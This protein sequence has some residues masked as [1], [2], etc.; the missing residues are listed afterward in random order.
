MADFSSI[1]DPY[2][3]L[4]ELIRRDF[5]AFLRKAYPWISGGE[6]MLWN[7]HLDA[8]ACQL[9]RVA[10]GD[11]RRLLVTL[12]PRHGKSKTIT[13]AWVAWCLGQD[14]SANFVCVSY[15]NELSGKLARDCLAIMQSAWYREA[16]PRT[17][18][19]AK[20]SAVADF[21]TT[22]G[23]GRLATSVTGTLTGRGGDI[24]ILDDVIKP[25]EA[26]SEVARNFVNNWYQST[27]ASRLNDKA[28]GAI[29][30]VMQRLHQ[31]DLAGMLIESGEWDEL[32]LPAIASEDQEIRLTRNRL[33][34]R[35]AGDILHPARESCEELMRIQRTIGSVIFAA[36]YQQQ[37]VPAEGNMIR[38]E[39]LKSYKVAPDLALVGGQIVQSWDTASKDGVLN[40]WSVCITAWICRQQIFIVDVWRQ[41]VAFPDLKK[42]TIQ[43]ARHYRA[44]VLL[45]EDQASG[46]QLLQTLRNENPVGVPAP[47]ARKPEADKRTRLAG[48]SA[49]IEAGQLLLPDDAPWLGPFKH[50]LLAFPSSR[51][52]DQVDALSQLLTW[53]GRQMRMDIPTIG[54]PIYFID[55]Q[56]WT[57]ETLSSYGSGH[58][59]GFLFRDLFGGAEHPSLVRPFR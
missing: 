8:I 49:M 34:R 44:Q 10:R 38:T 21:E 40:D 18:I 5:G 17:I 53:A 31:Y 47:I 14:P 7:W 6:L 9:E 51:H 16:F 26:Q 4:L 19:S 48:V 42:A 43:N 57:P 2:A 32:S 58:S 15:S 52:D 36:Q 55:G 33:H 20:R 11:C 13:V 25:E 37:P 22:A 50:E 35:K 46:T 1:D 56:E 39:W 29:I 30:T 41:K 27:L 28:S 3:L 59:S 12:P 24:I 45:I 23:G 54:M